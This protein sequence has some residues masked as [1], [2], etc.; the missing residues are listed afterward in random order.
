METWGQGNGDLWTSEWGLVEQGVETRG[1]NIGD[2]WRPYYTLTI[3]TKRQ[4]PYNGK[5]LMVTEVTKV[6]AVT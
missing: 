5:I 1:Q 2:L 6:T 4:K 3:V